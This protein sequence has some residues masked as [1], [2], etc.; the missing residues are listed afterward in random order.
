MVVAPNSAFVVGWAPVKDAVQHIADGV[1][2]S[3]SNVEVRHT[4]MRVAID[5]RAARAIDGRG[6]SLG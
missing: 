1:A 4:F 6:S 5:A 2:L 3:A